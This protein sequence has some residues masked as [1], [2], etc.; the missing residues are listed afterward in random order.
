MER[1]DVA[2]HQGSGE[3]SYKCHSSF[4]DAHVLLRQ[5]VSEV[6]AQMF[7]SVMLP[8]PIRAYRVEPG[9]VG[10]TCRLGWYIHRRHWGGG[11]R[12]EMRLMLSPHH[13]E[14]REANK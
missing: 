9:E 2:D 1:R 7:R 13:Q 5:L 3:S 14:R 11:S 6:S 8:R 10:E 4:E 12:H